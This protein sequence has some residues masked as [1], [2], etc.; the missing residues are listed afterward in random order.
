MPSSATTVPVALAMPAVRS[1]GP[2]GGSPPLL[3]PPMESSAVPDA[4]PEGIDSVSQWRHSGRSTSAGVSHC[5]ETISTTTEATPSASALETT[6]HE[7][8]SSGLRT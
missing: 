8:L 4:A 5:W 6:R 2:G 1:F 3:P 7:K